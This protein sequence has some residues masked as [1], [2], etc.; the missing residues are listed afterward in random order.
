MSEV[1]SEQE[2]Q[3]ISSINGQTGNGNIQPPGKDVTDDQTPPMEGVKG[4]ADTET[5]APVSCQSESMEIGK[6]DGVK[7]ET[8]ETESAEMAVNGVNPTVDHQG[9]SEQV[10]DLG[11]SYVEETKPSETHE[12]LSE[13]KQINGGDIGVEARKEGESSAKIKEAEQ[14]YEAV[15]IETNGEQ[16]EVLAESKEVE[17][18]HEPVAMETNGEQGET[19]P[20][21][22]ESEQNQEVFAM[23][24]KGEQ[25]ET[26]AESKEPEQPVAVDTKGEQDKVETVASEVESAPTEVEEGTEVEGPDVTLSEQAEKADQHE[27]Q[28]SEETK[29]TET[30]KL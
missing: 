22:K 10:E 30:G 15:A 16:G 23:E 24:T 1:D 12:E 7:D 11:E 4:T 17:E 27:D 29:V 8:K 5:A 9:K 18:S 3:P 13:D 21:N 28:P 14:N 26:S 19:S 2:K 20:A 25:V 6:D